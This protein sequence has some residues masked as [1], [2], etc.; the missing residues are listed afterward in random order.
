MRDLYHNQ[1]SLPGYRCLGFSPDSKYLATGEKDGKVRVR[2]PIP[3][4]T[5][6]FRFL[7]SSYPRYGQSLKGELEIR[8][9]IGKSSVL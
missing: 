2:F 5:K 8:S 1:R 9:G 6:A 4:R 3:L 7:I